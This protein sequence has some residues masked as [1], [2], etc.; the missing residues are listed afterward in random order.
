MPKSPYLA[1]NLSI[2]HTTIMKK[3]PLLICLACVLSFS[4]KLS[5]AEGQLLAGTAKINIT[6]PSNEVLHDSL[7]ARSLVLDVDGQQIAFV[8]IDLGIYT[9]DAVV[10]ACK[11]QYGLSEVMFCSSHTHSGPQAQNSSYEAFYEKQIIAA[12]G[13]A[14]KNK[15]PARIAYGRR[16]F[17]QLGFNRLIVREDGHAR[18]SWFADDHYT[19]ENPERI[20]HGPVDPE[21]GVIKIEDMQGQARVVMMNYACHSDIMCFNH[22]ISADYPGVACRRVEEAFGNKVNCLFV[23]G[24]G[25][26]VESLQIAR[27]RTGPDDPIKPDY[28]P[29]ERTGALLAYEVVKL[30]KQL[31]ATDGQTDMKFRSDS[32]TFTGRF[33]KNKSVHVH[34]T[35]VVLNNDLVLA[36]CP[37]ELFIQL[38]LDWK[39]KMELAAV[40]PFLLG[41]T[42]SRGQWPGYVPDIRSAALGGFGADQDGGMIEVGAGEAIINKQLE[43][44]YKLS[45]LMREKP[46]QP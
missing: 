7:Y 40:T 37:G 25:G 24:A 6:P 27:R 46:F 31:S 43:N 38:Q 35:T 3:A 22:E 36:A 9:S 28:A 4:A 29:M 2:Q 45:G 15:F 12:V 1:G 16:T 30:A 42:W 44:Y 20:P 26:N 21:V 19:T 13:M 33:D 32:L 34:L 14:V 18:E 5:A 41:Y 10:D 23:Q 17:P 8:S 39:K 11:K